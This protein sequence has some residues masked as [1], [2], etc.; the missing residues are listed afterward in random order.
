MTE[1][2]LNY[3]RM[4]E[5][6]LRGVVRR[7]LEQVRDHGLPGNHHFY[8]TFRTQAEGVD[9]PSRLRER[10]PDEMTIVLQHQYDDLSVDEDGFRVRLSFDNRPASLIIPFAA[11]TAFVDPSVQ[12]GLQFAAS[13]QAAP[14]DA[15]PAKSSGSVP[16]VRSNGEVVPVAK[17]DTANPDGDADADGEDQKDA[18]SPGAKVVSLESFRKK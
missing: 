1:N 14:T 5:T 17:A 15:L 11:L 10:Y 8:L 9:L 18:T 16:A 2:S 4:V 6:A 12:F 7:A 3:D 13:D